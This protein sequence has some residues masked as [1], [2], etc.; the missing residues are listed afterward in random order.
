MSHAGP[1]THP[2]LSV[3]IPAYRS[4][5][6]L[7]DVCAELQRHVAPLVAELEVIIVDDGS[8]DGTWATIQE[9]AARYP[10]V[11]GLT[12]LRNYGQHNALLAGLRQARLPLILTIDDD[13]Q[14][15]PDQVPLLLAALTDEVDLVY[16]RPVE[17]RQ[18][19]WRNVASTATKRAMAFALGPD[20]YPRPSAF[21]VFR[22]EL[23]SAADTISDPYVSIEVMLSW[24]TS[25]VTD[26]PVEFRDR[27]AGQSGYTI[28]KLIRHALNM[29]TGY[30]TRPLRW[31]SGFGF[32]IALFGFALLAFVMVSYAVNGRQVAG[33]TF[34][35]AALSL[36]SG[37]QLLSLGA[38]GEYI[39]RMHFR[40]MGKPPYVVRAMT[41]P[42]DDA[43]VEA[44]LVAGTAAAGGTDPR[45]S[46]GAKR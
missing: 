31:V 15:P 42:A 29:I 11:R 21:R 3:V 14:N 12:L 44:D 41:R 32:L 46:V 27:S 23:V 6:T 13:M 4:P 33:F 37:V 28:R 34:L 25:R 24:A 7:G 40:T 38:V 35:A 22:R 36:F 8:G 16:G 17:E 9:L 20:V 2:G 43:P 39:G 10:W 26:V 5:G 45:N 19:P 30:S 1:S 18:S